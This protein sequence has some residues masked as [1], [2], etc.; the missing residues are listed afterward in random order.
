MN[1][2]SVGSQ[3]DPYVISYGTTTFESILR[4]DATVASELHRPW[5]SI[6]DA[7]CSFP[8]DEV[9]CKFVDL[10]RHSCRLLSYVVE[11]VHR[12]RHFVMTFVNT[13][14]LQSG[15]CDAVHSITN[16]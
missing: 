5:F 6:A 8:S 9:S 14:P 4:R 2:D 3:R 12:R 16:L 15:K 7:R 10:S 1:R 11:N 13:T